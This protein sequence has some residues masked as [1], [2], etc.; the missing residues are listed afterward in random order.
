MQTNDYNGLEDYK[1]KTMIYGDFIEAGD[2]QTN[3]VRKLRGNL[4][5]NL[6]E[7]LDSNLQVDGVIFFSVKS[8]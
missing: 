8:G 4:D 6:Q 1:H 7:F 5:C 2:I 3:A